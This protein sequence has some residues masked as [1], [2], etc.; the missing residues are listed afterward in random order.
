MEQELEPGSLQF[1]MWASFCI[2]GALVRKHTISAIGRLR[3]AP[4][5]AT[6]CV[7]DRCALR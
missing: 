7:P 2:V 5:T 1:L 4:S 3:L 6:C